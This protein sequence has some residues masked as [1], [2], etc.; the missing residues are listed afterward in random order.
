MIQLLRA[1]VPSNV[2]TLLIT[3]T[4]VIFSCFL[5]ACFLLLP[6]DPVVYLLYD[7]GLGRILITTLTILMT[8]YLHDLYSNI[9]VRS[10]ALLVQ[11]VL[12][13][14]GV[15]F[16]FQA[17]LYYASADLTLPRWVMTLGGG[18]SLVAITSWRLLYSGVVLRAFGEE[19]V[20]FVGSSGPVREIVKHI[21]EHAELGLCIAGYVDERP[22][23]ALDPGVPW[24]GG[25]GDLRKA[26]E[27]TRPDRL[28]VGL[29]ERRGRTPLA[30]L[31][32]L[33]FSG[34]PIQE[35]ATAAETMFKWVSLAE[36]RPSQLIYGGELGPRAGIVALQVFYSRLIALIGLVVGLPVLALVAVAVKLSSRGPILFRQTRVGWQGQHFSLYKF[37]SMRVDA[38]AETGAVW[39][40][41]HDPRVT[42]V[43]RW[44]RR[45]R[46][47]EIPQFI[48][49]LRGEMSIVGPR[50]E[51][52]EFVEILSKQIPFFRQRLCVRPGITGWA[53]INHKYGDTLEDAARKLEYDL[54]YIKH[55]SP[56]LDAYIVLQTL[57]TVLLRRGAQ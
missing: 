20:V 18:L 23:P 56:S 52:P 24:L 38:E 36:L 39:A 45:L 57:K 37:R 11:Q 22:D 25:L 43:G 14:V 32:E 16:L 21:R 48:N 33:R 49:V 26:V 3:E 53:Q 5:I 54:Y 40:S 55:L 8:L 19:R 42:P 4:I 35:A 28:V 30:E 6:I 1:L 51:R 17:L 13:A 2:R 34:I 44:L 47:D 50:P 9:R 27:Q 10:R 31:L 41:K 46:L 15:A 12:Q 29:S 7:G